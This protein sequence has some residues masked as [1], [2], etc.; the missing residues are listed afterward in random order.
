MKSPPDFTTIRGKVKNTSGNLS[1][2]ETTIG[3]PGSQEN[4][5]FASPLSTPYF[6]A[7]FIS[8]ASEAEAKQ[9]YEEVKQA[10]KACDFN[11]GKLRS[12]EKKLGEGAIISWQHVEDEEADATQYDNLQIEL[13]NE[14]NLVERFDVELRISY[15][16][17]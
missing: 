7:R 14:K 17:N 13:T 3:L 16:I 5:V 9:K 2:Y 6:T 15:P 1:S 4:S 11:A 8:T 10:L 12:S